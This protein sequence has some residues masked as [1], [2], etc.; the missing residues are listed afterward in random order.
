[1]HPSSIVY[2][3]I[4][5]EWPKPWSIRREAVD[6]FLAG[7]PYSGS[8]ELAAEVGPKHVLWGFAEKAVLAAWT[9]GA[10]DDHVYFLPEGPSP[11]AAVH[12]TFSGKREAN[13]DWPSTH[14]FT[15]VHSL[16]AFLEKEP[17]L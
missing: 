15:D 11:L 10:S 2:D 16:K 9:G 4:A 14:L 13:G 1:M 17:Y 8:E 7:N 3:L 12:L 6:A 5:L